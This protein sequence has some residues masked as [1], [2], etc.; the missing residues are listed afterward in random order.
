MTPDLINAPNLITLGRIISIPVFMAC[1]IAYRDSGVELY[2]HL[3]LGL[4]LLM[5]VSDWIDGVIARRLKIV[6]RFGQFLDPAADKLLMLG[7]LWVLCFSGMPES[8]SLPEFYGF[9]YTIRDVLLLV[10]YLLL[11]LVIDHVNIVA[12]QTGKLAT[13]FF[14]I[15]VAGELAGVWEWMQWALIWINTAI[16]AWSFPFYV[17]DGYRQWRPKQVTVSN[18][19]S[20][21]DITQ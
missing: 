13:V 11:H 20:A 15:C 21:P 9:I 6:S 7:T 19:S 12:T 3:S 1:L 18:S 16:L 10:L 8:A 17:R 5:A 2:R 4:F 14:F